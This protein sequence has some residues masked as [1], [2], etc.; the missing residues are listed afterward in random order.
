MRPIGVAR[1]LTARRRDGSEFPVEISLSPLQTDRGTLVSAA[2][3]D[4][5]DRRRA[6]EA[7]EEARQREAAASTPVARARAH[8]PNASPVA[9]QSQ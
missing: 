1:Q 7:L 8:T 5:T 2:V 3:R 6:E 4:I 9:I